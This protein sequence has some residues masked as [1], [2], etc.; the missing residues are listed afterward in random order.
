LPRRDDIVTIVIDTKNEMKR[1][2]DGLGTRVNDLERDLRAA[3]T[4]EFSGLRETA[5]AD[6]KS[7]Q[8]ETRTSAYNAG[9][10]ASEAV[11]AVADL[12][13]D[14]DRLQHGLEALRGD[15]GKVLKALETAV[16]AR[17]PTAVGSAD[18]PDLDHAGTGY[19][20]APVLLRSSAAEDSVGR[21]VVQFAVRRWSGLAESRVHAG[22]NPGGSEW[23]TAR[24]TSAAVRDSRYVNR[25]VASVIR[26]ETVSHYL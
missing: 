18:D 20:L 8:H 9:K 11:A 1:S 5:L 3:F 10:R 24:A 21:I 12:R 17:M 22:L 23:P 14:V 15:V 7:S 4:T 16:P 13:R 26:P 19:E 6:V 25:S 2:I